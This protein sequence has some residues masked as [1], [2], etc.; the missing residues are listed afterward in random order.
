MFETNRINKL[1]NI[2][3]P[4]LQG[5]MAWASDSKLA[6]AVSDAGGLGIIGCGGRKFEWVFNEIQKAK[7]ITSKDIGL[8]F[9]LEGM[10]DEE[11][12]H[13]IENAIQNGKN[14]FTVSG[15]NRYL[16][17]LSKYGDDTLII[18]VIGNVMEAKLAE[19]TG[20]KAVICEGQESGGSIGR[21]SLFSLL[22]QIVDA[23]K[24]PVIAAGGIADSRGMRAAFALGAQ[25]IQM[26][27]RFLA[28]E[29]CRITEEYKKRIIKAKDID[30]IVIFNK[31]KYPARV[32]RNKFSMEYILKES[33][34]TSQEDLISLSKGRLRLAVETDANAGALMAGESAGLIHGVKSARDII[35]EIVLGFETS[36]DYVIPDKRISKYLKHKPPILLVDEII[37]LK[38]G[39]KSKTSL[40]LRKDR[41]FFKCHYPDYP[42]MPGTLLLEA[43]SQTMTLAVTSMDEFSNEWEGLLLLSG[44]TNVK[45]KKEVLPELKLII[46]AKIDSF[47]R[48]T[49]NG[50]I[51]CETDGKLICSCTMTIV[52]PSVI[53]ELS[54]QIRRDK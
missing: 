47:K 19:R 3:Y 10:D 16:R 50:N 11:A 54:N 34:D 48:G 30:S 4:I 8:N 7:K 25:G 41:W 36:R 53:K 1:L 40:N 5:G 43:M 17:F 18:P 2:E 6:C 21:L 37:E 38:P 42:V 29:E 51:K 32:I 28:S 52:I 12:E 44:I 31:V 22:P 23:V 27:T 39:I 26:G 45:F 24:I 49:I 9:P 33:N 13:I 35:D 15:S 46:T 14:I 20:A